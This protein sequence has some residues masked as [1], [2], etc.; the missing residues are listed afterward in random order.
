MNRERN[1]KLEA[2]FD[3]AIDLSSIERVAFLDRECDDDMALRRELEALLSSAPPMAGRNQ[4][5]VAMRT[6]RDEVD[7]LV[8]PVPDTPTAHRNGVPEITLGSTIYQYELIRKLG[9][10]GMGTVYLARDTKLGRRVAIKFLQHADRSLSERFMLEAQATARCSHENIVVIYD[11]KEL[12]G[13]PFM[14]LEYLKGE[15]LDQI[16]GD[17]KLPP[18]RAVQL[19]MP[20]VR[21]LVCAHQHKIVHRDLKPANIVMTE[22][23][24][25]KVLDFGVAKV[26]HGMYASAEELANT[27][28]AMGTGMYNLPDIT[29][30]G[31]LVGTL[32]YMSPEQ[33]GADT[34]DQR[35]DLWAVGLLLYRMVVGR[36]P[37]APLGGKQLMV[38]RVLDQPMPSA[39]NTGVDMPLQ[40]ADIIDSCLKKRKAERMSS[41]E[42]LLA[43]LE[44]LLPGQRPVELSASENPYTGLTAFQETDA[45][46]FFGRTREISTV[47]ARL[48]G[49]PLLGIVGPSGVG[50]SSFVRAGV[51]PALKQSG[52][53]WETM[54][55]RPG[56]HPMAALANIVVPL[57]S[58][59]NTNLTAQVAEHQTALQ[60]LY[61]EPGYL[62]TLL[63]NRART[64]SRKILL[65]VDQFEEL[66]TLIRDA[67]ERMAFTACLAGMADD[68][69]S[70]LRLMLSI[71]S[72]FLDR[73]AEDQHF[74]SELS[75]NLVFLAPPDRVGLRDAIVRPAEMVRY[76]F[77]TPAMVEDMLDTLQ[78]TPG[79]LPLLQFA[80]SKLWDARD[81][82]RRL[83]T[84][85]SYRRLGGVS[86]ALATH[87]DAVLGALPP[88]AQAMAKIIFLQ[89]V[90]PERTRGIASVS[91]PC[92]LTEAPDEAERV[93]HQLVDARLL[94]V[95][96]SR[97]SN[98][99]T[100]EIIH[101][102]LIHTW[103]TLAHWLDENQEDA[104]FLKQLRTATKQWEARG[105]SPDLLWRGETLE[106]ARTWRRRY[107]GVLPPLQEQFLNASFRLAARA[108]R[109]KRVVVFGIIALLSLLVVA[110][111]IALV[112]IRDAEHHAHAQAKEAHAAKKLAQDQAAKAIAAGEKVREQL[113]TIRKTQARAASSEAR[114]DQSEE[115]LARKNQELQAA[116]ARAEAATKRANDLLEKERAQSN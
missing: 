100:V 36:H 32:P 42:K 54:V 37:L 96:R 105:H 3:A 85:Q 87:A 7:T 56:R 31:A 41:A 51:I 44:P 53:S 69:L 109:I 114:A 10:G 19:M 57:L 66:F 4:A 34:V 14:V 22:A 79:S 81:R 17:D 46:R 89:L 98:G 70:P 38:T 73:V 5:T 108:V 90:T 113:D 35:S 48:H 15:T 30:H 29:H 12:R 74:M 26:L 99:A 93:I 111:G 45:N 67:D 103:P 47:V 61:Q 86:G 50:K 60:H 104:E 82:E 21:A 102:S 39:H 72:D 64:H 107:R 91:E 20:V 33:W 101:E 83:L 2:L 95:Q 76:R 97:G 78:V 115:N 27:A 110:A 59:N 106:E 80:A 52:E 11:V 23:G 18:S 65:F 25:I 6:P 55:I 13:V 28:I 49:A 75:Q 94:V 63:R 116:L 92:E 84:E 77:E 62:G 40:L 8:T 71:R 9:S 24:T 16:L 43:A 58:T 88:R 1:R 68:P 112:K